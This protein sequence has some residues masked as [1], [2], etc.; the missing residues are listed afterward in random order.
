MGHL[1]TDARC[2]PATI[3]ARRSCGPDA[4][5]LEVD[6]AEPLASLTPGRFA[7]LAPLEP[8][9]L[10]VPRPFSIYEQL[11]S[12]RV[13]FLVQVLG[14]G[15]LVLG[16]IPLGEDL[17][18]IAPLGNGFTV[19]AP[20]RE[21]VLVAGGVGSVPFLIYL[22]QR[23]F[24]AKSQTESSNTHF[25][26]GARNKERLYD[27][28]SFDMDGVNTIHATDDGSSGFQGNV[29]EALDNELESGRIGADALFCACGPS[30]M[31]HGFDGFARARQLDFQVSLETYMGCGFGVCNGCPTATAS[32]GQ[33]GDWP[34]AK[35]CLDG[36]IFDATDIAPFT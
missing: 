26:Y 29:V 23:M 4:F 12:Q 18:C 34:W 10:T 11:S 32:G 30:P 35:A 36:P 2:G 31:L 17:L 22:Q 14:K 3:V 5:I 25:L 1:P 8:N 33:F 19:A 27:H 28:A 6:L 9:E 20:E 24:A 13:S 15:T 7:M 16:E 21:V